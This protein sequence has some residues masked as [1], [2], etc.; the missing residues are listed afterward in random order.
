[1]FLM[2]LPPCGIIQVIFF[3]IFADI[4]KNAI[5]HEKDKSHSANP[6]ELRKN[7]YFMVYSFY[8]IEFCQ[9]V[10]FVQP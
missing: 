10:I 8:V 3:N 1:M 6:S 7:E 4:L 5:H 2:F 9:M